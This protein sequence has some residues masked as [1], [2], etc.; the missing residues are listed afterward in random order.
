MQS[1]AQIIPFSQPEYLLEQ[2]GM[3]AV[4][5]DC[6][7]FQPTFDIATVTK[8]KRYQIRLDRNNSAGLNVR[9]D[10]ITAHQIRIRPADS[11]RASPPKANRR[12]PEGSSLLPVQQTLQML[13]QLTEIPFTQLDSHRTGLTP[14]ASMATVSYPSICTA[15]SRE[16]VRCCRKAH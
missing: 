11:C 7:V 3:G 12:T 5:V 10:R 13:G 2:T 14:D 16:G 4:S 1:R 6:P 9:S 15:I 8:T